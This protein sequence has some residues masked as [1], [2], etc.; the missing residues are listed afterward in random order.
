MSVRSDFFGDDLLDQ[1]IKERERSLNE[2]R[3]KLEGGAQLREKLNGPQSVNEVWG[4]GH[5]RTVVDDSIRLAGLKHAAGFSIHQVQL[6]YRE[7][8]QAFLR[9]AQLSDFRISVSKP[10]LDPGRRAAK[11][12]GDRPGVVKVETSV[13]E[14]TGKK[15]ARIHS[16]RQPAGL[17]FTRSLEAAIISGDANLAT[18]IAETY[19]YTGLNDGAILRWFVLGKDEEVASHA[20]IYVPWAAG[21]K[22]GDWPYPRRQFPLGILNKDDSLLAEGV[23]NASSAFAS[24]WKPSRYKTP[25]M[26][27]RLNTPENAMVEAGKFLVNMNWVL[28]EHGLAFGI[29]AARRGMKTFLSDESVWSEWIPRDLVIASI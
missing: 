4:G 22:D 18:A 26:L 12:Y 2:T 16:M 24:R 8:G 5:H 21:N 6:H 11:K 29:L 9:I 14:A 25:S 28:Y 10:F 13:D 1:M 19:P 7:A 15:L 20:K 3:S 27:K 23:A 17:I